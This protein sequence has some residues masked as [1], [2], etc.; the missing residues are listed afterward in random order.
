MIPSLVFGILLCG[1]GIASSS[2]LSSFFC[3]VFCL[4]SFFLSSQHSDDETDRHRI[5]WSGDSTV[6][7]GTKVSVHKSDSLAWIH[8]ILIPRTRTR[9]L[10]VQ[11]T[12]GISTC[13]CTFAITLV[14]EVWC[15]PFGMAIQYCDVYVQYYNV[16]QKEYCMHHASSTI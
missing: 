10:L 6:F 13:T 5:K 1:F 2:L 16:Y 7:F 14:V 3:V 9:A 8:S 15:L 4:L 12:D 11:D